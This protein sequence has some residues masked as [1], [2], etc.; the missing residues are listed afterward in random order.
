ML[1]ELH[2][3]HLILCPFTCLRSL[4]QWNWKDTSFKSHWNNSIYCDQWK[5]TS[6]LH[7]SDGKT[8]DSVSFLLFGITLFIKLI[9]FDFES[10]F[11]TLIFF[12]KKI[13]HQI[14]STLMTSDL[15]MA[16]GKIFDFV[17]FPMFWFI[18]VIKLRNFDFESDWNTLMFL[19]K[20]IWRHIG[21]CHMEKYLI[22][23]HFFCLGS[24]YS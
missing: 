4:V 6:D 8:S 5:M 15:N 19:I 21:I 3:S 16:C 14:W 12:I 7:M 18:I 20:K 11:S 1:P 2:M 13:L 22:L 9:N 10:H 23:F 17:S 24:H